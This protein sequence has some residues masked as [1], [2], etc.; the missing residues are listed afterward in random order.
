VES[1]ENLSNS[2]VFNETVVENCGITRLKE[3]G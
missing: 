3:M 1:V 2:G